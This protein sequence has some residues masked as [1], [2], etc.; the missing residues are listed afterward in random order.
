LAKKYNLTLFVFIFS[1][2]LLSSFMFNPI[3]IN[4]SEILLNY[5]ENKVIQ[6]TN[7][8]ITWTFMMYLCGDNDLEKNVLEILNELEKGMNYVQNINIIAMVDRINLSRRNE[9]Y[10]RADGN[11]DETRIYK[12]IPDTRN[13][14]KSKL[15]LDLQE[16]NMGDKA[17]LQLFLRYCVIHYPADKYLLNL[18]DHGGGAY[19]I[20]F[21]ETSGGDGLSISEITEAISNVKNEINLEK[22]DI[23]VFS[24]CNMAT[25]EVIYELKDVADYLLCSQ[26]YT[27]RGNLR[28]NDILSRISGHNLFTD[29]IIKNIIE[30]CEFY[31]KDSDYSTT[32]SAIDLS[33]IPEEWLINSFTNYLIQAINKENLIS[34]IIDCR[35]KVQ[36]FKPYLNDSYQY[37]GNYSNK[38]YI[39]IIDYL[40]LIILDKTLN[41]A[42][43]NLIDICKQFNSTLCESIIYNYNHKSYNNH[44]NGISLFFPYHHCNIYSSITTNYYKV[45]GNLKNLTWFEKINWVNFLE[46]FYKNDRDSDGLKDWYEISCQLDPLNNDS[47]SDLISDKNDDQ[48]FD[49]LSNISEFYNKTDPVS[50]DTDSDGLNDLEE[51]IHYKTNPCMADSD[52]DEFNDFIEIEKG[53]NPLNSKDHPFK[54]ENLWF[55]F[56]LTLIPI[57]TTFYF[58]I[59]YKKLRMRIH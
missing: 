11:W 22:I 45:E 53:F 2:I 39:D 35:R 26:Y 17:T 25:L 52:N 43:P 32:F 13:K 14:I 54:K 38:I 46:E 57:F 12:I 40:R 58:N 59:K 4:T 42:I 49:G 28:W 29:I 37:I 34:K 31:W 48:D 20:C 18:Y 6:N 19:G 10:S 7:S 27:Y 44:A 51:I 36:D 41:T 55:L 15:L 50:P 24:A 3:T 30:S 8:D 23:L 33:K 16:K 5:K 47:D 21:D 9:G 1:T 56:L